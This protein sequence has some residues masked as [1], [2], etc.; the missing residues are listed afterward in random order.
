M[1]DLGKVNIQN[2]SKMD[3]VGVRWIWLEKPGRELFSRP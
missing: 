1:R 3:M 2:W